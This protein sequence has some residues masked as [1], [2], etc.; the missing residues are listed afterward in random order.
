MRKEVGFTLVEVLISLAILGMLLTGLSMIY[1]MGTE[2]YHEGM[3]QMD[4][5]QSARIGMDKM[6]R[7][8]RY[9]EHVEVP[10]SE[11]IRF[12]LK[13]EHQTLAFFLRDQRLVYEGRTNGVYDFQVKIARDITGLHF[14]QDESQRIIMQIASGAGTEEPEVILTSSVLPRNM[15]VEGLKGAD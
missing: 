2:R 1:T 5:Q 10:S 12:R 3:D 14:S 13:D 7:E 8:L 6:V 9:A 15:P 4:Y 11:E